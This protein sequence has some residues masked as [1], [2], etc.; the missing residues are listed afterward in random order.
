VSLFAELK[1]TANNE[2]RKTTPPPSRP[3]IAPNVPKTIP[4]DKT[5]T[6]FSR[7]TLRV[8]ITGREFESGIANGLD[9]FWPL[10]KEV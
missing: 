10:S 7:T 4:E 1:P 9:M 8:S 5:P 6:R 2:N 3:P